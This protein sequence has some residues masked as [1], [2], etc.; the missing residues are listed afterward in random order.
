MG[1]TVDRTG[2]IANDIWVHFGT[3]GWE[4]ALVPVDL[5]EN[6]GYPG[7]TLLLGILATGYRG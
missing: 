3:G 5:G 7:M 4:G 1:L 6:E 2:G